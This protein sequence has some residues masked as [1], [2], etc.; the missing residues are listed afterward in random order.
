[1]SIIT[2]MLRQDAVYWPHQG[3]DD[4]GQPVWGNPVAV[5]VRWEASSI[6]FINP[7][8]RSELSKALV[9]INIDVA[10]AGVLWLARTP[11]K[12]DS[13]I[14]PVLEQINPSLQPYDNPD[15]A[16]IRRFDKM[17]DFRCRKF[18]RI[19]YIGVSGLA[20]APGGRRISAS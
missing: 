2:R 19:A 6:E 1:M 11:I 8:G 12:G 20:H 4:N 14:P 17:G 18:L 7:D 15:A 5:K 3:D 10:E 16:E 9:Y 13:S